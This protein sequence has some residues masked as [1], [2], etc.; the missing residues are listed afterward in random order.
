M[1]TVENPFIQ[2]QLGQ[3]ENP[4]GA[5]TQYCCDVY[6]VVH[7]HICQCTYPH[8]L[9]NITI[10]IMSLVEYPFVQGQPEQLENPEDAEAMITQYFIHF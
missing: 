3:L 9:N 7:T 10:I 8:S 5:V 6:L 1:F 4:E 2:G